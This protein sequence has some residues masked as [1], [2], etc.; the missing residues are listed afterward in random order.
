MSSGKLVEKGCGKVYKKVQK[1][2]AKIVDI[3]VFSRYHRDSF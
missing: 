1:K 2:Y 3:S